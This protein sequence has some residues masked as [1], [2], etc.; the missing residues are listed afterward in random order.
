[1]LPSVTQCSSHSGARRTSSYARIVT[2]PLPRRAPRRHATIRARRAHIIQQQQAVMRRRARLAARGHSHARPCRQPAMHR[3]TERAPL[4]RVLIGCTN[5]LLAAS[6]YSTTRDLKV[7]DAKNRMA[8]RSK[9][10]KVERAP[11][12]GILRFIALLWAAAAALVVESYTRLSQT[13]L[14]ARSCQHTISVT[15]LLHAASL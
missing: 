7:V 2:A 14:Y 10:A 1:M 12:W 8:S 13:P 5:G 11:F 3:R 15:G 6:T 4:S 9:L